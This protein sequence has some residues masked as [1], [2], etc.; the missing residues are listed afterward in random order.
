VAEDLESSI[1]LQKV[2]AR[3]GVASRRAAEELIVDGRVSVDGQV[4]TE[5]GTRVD[6]ATS[7]IHVDGERVPTAPGIVVLSLNKPR[8]MVTTMADEQGRPCVGDVVPDRRVGLFHVGRL[9]A[10]TEG[11]LLLTNDGEL[12]NRLT[13]PSHEVAKTYRATVEGAITKQAMS[14]L[15]QGVDLDDGTIACDRART[16][17]RCPIAA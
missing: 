5:L 6:P 7:V 16:I 1:R 4:V 17:Q 11:L 13:H 9:D 12:G 2:L 14:A 10:D 15:L 8:G 3:A